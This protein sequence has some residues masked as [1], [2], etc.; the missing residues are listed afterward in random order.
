M[1]KY[2]TV[3]LL[4]AAPFCTAAKYRY[5]NKTAL[6]VANYCASHGLCHIGGNP[7]YEGLGCAS[8]PEAAYKNCCFGSRTDLITYDSAVIQAKNGLWVACRRYVHKSK[9]HMIPVYLER[10]GIEPEPEEE[11]DG[12]VYTN[13]V[14]EE[15]D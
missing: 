8:T 1:N 5:A 15:Q 6:D 13:T 3:L 12:A 9:A 10:A 7:S 2:V 14:A 11:S 4:V